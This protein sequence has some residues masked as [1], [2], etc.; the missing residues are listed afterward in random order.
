MEKILFE[1]NIGLNNN[2]FTFYELKSKLGNIVQ[3]VD[4]R[5][6]MGEYVGESE[7]TAIALVMLDAQRLA[8]SLEYM[9]EVFTQECIPARKLNDRSSG[10][11][12][13][14]RGYKGEDRYDYDEKFFIS[15]FKSQ[16]CTQ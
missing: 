1:L 3:L 11:L 4:V 5:K 10:R 15:F 6:D 8:A 12:I 16:A 2:P 7:P 14:N 13:Y 9:C